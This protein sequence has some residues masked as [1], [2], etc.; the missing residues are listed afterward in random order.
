[1]GKK[2][3]SRQRRWQLVRMIAG[4]CTIC[5]KEPL[6]RGNRCKKCYYHAK[7]TRY[8]KKVERGLCEKPWCRELAAHSLTSVCEKH[9][10]D[11]KCV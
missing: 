2:K 3:V 4:L 10:G 11:V 6:W 7:E 5:G 1:V 8:D 9:R